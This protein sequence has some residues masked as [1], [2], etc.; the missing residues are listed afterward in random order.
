MGR[1]SYSVSRLLLVVSRSVSKFKGRASSEKIPPVLILDRLWNENGRNELSEVWS[2]SHLCQLPPELSPL[3]GQRLTQADEILKSLSIPG[4]S[5]QD[6]AAVNTQSMPSSK[7]SPFQSPL[8]WGRVGWKETWGVASFPNVCRPLGLYLPNLWPL[9]AWYSSSIPFILPK[10][11]S[12]QMLL[13]YRQSFTVLASWPHWGL[14][15]KVSST[16]Q[17]AWHWMGAVA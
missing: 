15:M 6:A 9:L 2:S 14:L 11:H 10:S 13:H 3:L 1:W 17:H 5:S 12:F 7:T 4:T 8:L 16:E